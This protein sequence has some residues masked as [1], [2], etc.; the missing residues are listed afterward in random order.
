MVDGQSST[1]GQSGQNAQT[2][3]DRRNAANAENAP[4]A[5]N[6]RGFKPFGSPPPFDFDDYKDTFDIWKEKWSIFINLSTID[7]A[8]PVDDCKRY[9]A[10]TLKSCLSTPALQAVLSMGLTAA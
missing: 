5:P 6:A 4:N 2:G 10:S 8:L 3:Q 7:T 1:S 9:M